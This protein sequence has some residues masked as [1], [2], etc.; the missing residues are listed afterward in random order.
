MSWIKVLGHD[1]RCGL[2]RRRYLLIP[3][4][5]L[6]AC[7]SLG[8]I[9]RFRGFQGTWLDFMLYFFKGRAPIVNPDPSEVIFL[10]FEWLLV[11][12]GCLFL[13][14]DYLLLDLTNAGQQVI[15]RSR[16]RRGWYLS[17]CVWNLC[18]TGLYFVL[19]ALTAAVAVW[20]Y[21]GEF[22]FFNT[23]ALSPTVFG[24]VIVDNVALTAWQGLVA[25]VLLPFLS[26]AAL[27][28]LQMTLCLALKPVL[29]FLICQGLLVLAVY[30][31]SPLSLGIGAMVMRNGWVGTEAAGPGMGGVDPLITA[32]VAGGI[33]II[34]VIAGTVRFRHT[35]ILGMEE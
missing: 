4:L 34:C 1:L 21:G 11:T 26:L 10:P 17:K 27:N 9:M 25:G 13:N 8:S 24:E 16:D 29:S 31:N 15:V 33:L 18:G 32:L 6:M 19:L 23:P 2:L 7:I 5:V 12:G 14:L 30:W 3:L 22:S 28:M 35:D 20:W